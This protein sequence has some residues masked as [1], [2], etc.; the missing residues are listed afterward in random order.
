MTLLGITDTQESIFLPPD[1]LHTYILGNTGM[2]K[3]TLERELVNG[4]IEEGHGICVIDPHGERSGCLVDLVLS[5]IPQQR[6][7]D[8]ILFDINNPTYVPGLKPFYCRD[9]HDPIAVQ[10]TISTAL[11]M[12]EKVYNVD[13]NTMARI[14]AYIKSL[15][16]LFIYDESLTLLDIP[17]LLNPDSKYDKKR[18]LAVTQLPVPRL[19]FYPRLLD[20]GIYQTCQTRL[21]SG[22][23]NL[24]NT[25]EIPGTL[26]S[27]ALAD[28]LSEQ[29]HP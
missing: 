17:Q 11:N 3:T 2:G 23:G 26:K 4:S 10:D 29:K 13:R 27:S 20:G 8:V 6:L 19:S 22:L 16:Y 15:I 9:K 24:R 1:T 14:I 5:D 12:F 7:N 28:V 21:Q 18:L 25:H